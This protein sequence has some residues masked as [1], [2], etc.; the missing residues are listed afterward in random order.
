ME[1]PF[2]MTTSKTVSVNVFRSKTKSLARIRIPTQRRSPVGKME[3]PFVGLDCET[4]PNG[5]ILCLCDSDGRVLERPESFEVIVKWLLAIK[6]VTYAGWNAG[7]DTS[8]IMKYIP[9][10][11]LKQVV[12][13]DTITFKVG[14]IALCGFQSDYSP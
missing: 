2:A 6:K 9:E 1:E 8:V 4:D 10:E 5:D 7:F 3:K 14:A 13:D 11:I 12:A